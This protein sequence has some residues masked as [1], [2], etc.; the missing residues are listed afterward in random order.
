[1]EEKAN[2][3]RLIFRKIGIDQSMTRATNRDK[4]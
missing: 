2:I 4:N 1:M 3:S